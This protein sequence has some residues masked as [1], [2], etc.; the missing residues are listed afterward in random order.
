MVMVADEMA[1]STDLD[2]A[3]LP[4]TNIPILVSSLFVSLLYG[5]GY[6]VWRRHAEVSDTAP[7]NGLPGARRVRFDSD[8]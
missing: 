7:A 6:D 4:C 5:N 1:S 3:Q 2:I 8:E